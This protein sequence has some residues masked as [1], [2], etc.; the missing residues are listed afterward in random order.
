MEPTCSSSTSGNMLQS[1][2]S[3]YKKSSLPSDQSCIMLKQYLNYD[4]STHRPTHIL[5]LTDV[6]QVESAEN[7]NP[8]ARPFSCDE[9]DLSSG[10]GIDVAYLNTSFLD[11]FANLFEPNLDSN[12]DSSRFF[13]SDDEGIFKSFS[14]N[15]R[16]FCNI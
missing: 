1:S 12:C 13:G 6:H 2:L 15:F 7:F 5:G 4:N 11:P 8:L 9:T 10:I 3:P 14:I 16:A